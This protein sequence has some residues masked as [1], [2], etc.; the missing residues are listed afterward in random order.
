MIESS[1]DSINW[2]DMHCLSYKFFR[3]I[4][5]LIVF[6]LFLNFE[7]QLS[8]EAQSNPFILSQLQDEYNL[9]NNVLVLDDPEGTIGINDLLIRADN[10][11]Q[12]LPE[13]IK[14]DPTHTYWL[15]F[16]ID[17]QIPDYRIFKD[18]KLFVGDVDQFEVYQVSE[19]N[20]IIDHQVGGP[21]NPANKKYIKYGNKY[22]RV[23]INLNDDYPQKFYISLNRL[24]LKEISIDVRLRK[25]DFYQSWNYVLQSRMDWLFLGFIVTMLVFNLLFFGGTKDKAFL[26]HA[27]F[28][29]GVF[30]FTLEFFAVTQDLPF[31][32]DHPKWKQIIDYIALGIMDIAYYQFIRTYL[33]LDQTMPKWDRIFKN[34]IILK[35]LVFGF[36]ILHCFIYYN[37]PF[38]DR[39]AAIFL[40]SQYLVVAFFLVPVFKTGD[41]KGWFIIVGSL[42]LFLGIFLN[43]ISVIQGQGLLILYTLIGITGE[44]SA[45][46]LGLSYRMKQLRD[47]ALHDERKTNKRLREI[48]QLKNQFLAN[49]S[50][51]LKTPLQGIIG[52][53]ENL[54]EHTANQKEAEDL[55]IIINSGKRLNH[56]IN[57]IL[58]FSKLKNHDLNLNIKSIDLYVLVEIVIKMIQPLLQN[59][60]VKLFHSIPNDFP[61][62]Q[63]DENRLQQV[64]YNLIHNAIKFTE[65][66]HVN[67]EAEKTDKEIIIKVKDSGIGIAPD[68]LEIIFEEF[69]QADGS[70]SRDFTGSGLGLSISKQLIEL[71][72]GRIGVDSEIGKGSTFK[73][74]LPGQTEDHKSSVNLD[75]SYINYK[76]VKTEILESSLTFPVDKSVSPPARKQVKGHF[77]ILIVDDEPINQQVLRSHLDDSLYQINSVLNG[78][79]AIKFI[80]EHDDIDL[81]LL[82]LMLPRMSGYEVC[83]RIREKYLPSEMPVIMVTAK[84]Q[85]EDLIQGFKVGA[86]DY[87]AKP[88]SRDEFLARVKTQLNLYNYSK[89]AGRF[90]PQDFIKSLGRETITE[91]KIGD[92]VEKNVTVLFSDIRK[93]T[94]IAEKMDLDENF[95]FVLDHVREMGP[96]IFDNQGFVNEYL[97][98]SIMA[99]FPKNPEDALHAAIK[100]QSSLVDRNHQLGPDSYEMNIGIGFHT[101]NLMMGII[102]DDYHSKPVTIADTVNIAARIESLT[103]YFGAKILF[104]DSSL[105]GMIN[106]NQFDLRYI[107]NVQVKGKSKFIGL[108]ECINGD[109]EFIYLKKKASINRFKEGMDFYLNKDFPRAAVAFQEI[110]KDNSEDHVANHYLK[111]S[112]YY[113]SNPV[114]EDWTG[115]E[116]MDFK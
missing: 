70:I 30:A 1:S 84:N 107:G 98:D 16:E 23:N 104:S 46:S 86:N 6:T 38:T 43:A 24:G 75:D 103:K 74:F 15:Y 115:T 37:I 55:S 5:F 18:W 9:N 81:V 93:Y 32:K 112:A 40:I 67:V 80:N 108:Y 95:D 26:Y 12:V 85:M 48:D 99:I 41:K 65:K 47:K 106:T 64:L 105:N 50:H 53:S 44:I 111:K 101:G 28:I 36:I 17:N 59:R 2:M 31:V 113:I 35:V 11:F 52:L 76:K 114:S 77:K 20:Q 68:K 89:A 66:G 45:F 34:L 69:Q 57:D 29:F 21:L 33:H 54:L 39:I 19:S 62:V 8:I 51:E 49:T 79:E 88:F 71:H 78:P 13:D 42:M 56:L 14:L 109:E 100:M 92:H 90:V 63:A 102:G 7:G 116:V 83:K 91:V 94:T 72:G 4:K 27:L 87:L 97:G 3:E 25:Y 73:I 60:Q 96:I 22:N 61:L 58:D 110:L 82:D 10:N